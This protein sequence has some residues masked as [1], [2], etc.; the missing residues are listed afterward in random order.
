ME[1]NVKLDFREIFRDGVK[2]IYLA[3][4]REK[5]EGFVKTEMNFR[6]TQNVEN[7]TEDILA[8][9]EDL[10]IMDFII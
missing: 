6:V 1:E 3:E 8:F 7:L 2:W 4:D 9:E 5:V 10:C